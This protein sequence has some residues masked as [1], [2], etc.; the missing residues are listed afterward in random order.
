ML[1]LLNLKFEGHM[2]NQQFLVIGGIQID[3][4]IQDNAADLY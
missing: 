1:L 4:Q 2:Y 3:Q